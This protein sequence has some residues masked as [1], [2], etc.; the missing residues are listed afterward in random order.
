MADV[1]L[2]N[3]VKVYPGQ[4]YRANDD[5]SLDVEDGE[6]VVLLGPSGCGKT[7][8]LRMVAGLELPTDGQ[9]VIGRRDVTYL[10]PRDRNLSMVFQSYAVF[11]HGR[12]SCSSS[13]SSWTGTPH[14]CPAGNGSALRWPGPSWWMPTCCSW[15]S[16]CPIWTPC[17]GWRSGRS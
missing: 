8:L 11:P 10:P 6:F 17:S 2:R 15:T 12:P 1:R 3:L 7:T 13:P 16:R 9:V 4:K 14:S 5:V